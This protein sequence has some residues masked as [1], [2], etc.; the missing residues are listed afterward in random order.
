MNGNVKIAIDA[1]GGDNAPFEIVKGAIAAVNANS[2]ISV[3]LTGKKEEIDKVLKDLTF[4]KERVEIVEA[5]EII[6]M[7]ESPVLAIRQKKDSSLVKAMYLVKEGKCDACVSAGSTGAILVGGQTI[8]GRQKGIQRAP[9]APLIPTEKGKALLIDCGANVDARPQQL[10]QFA[11]IGSVYMEEIMKIKNPKVALVN[12]G[13]E[14]EKGNQ[15]VKETFPLLKNSPDIN[16][17][18]NI[19]ARDIPAG[20]ADV[21]VCDAFVGNVILKMYEGVAASLTKILKDGMMSSLRGKIGGAIVKPV[22]KA[23]LADYDTNKLGGA[24]MLGLNHLVI[25]AH[26]SSN[27]ES[28]QK[29]C[30]QCAQF[31]ESD[32]TKKLQAKIGLTEDI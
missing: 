26:G 20:H 27:A 22:L 9:L 4:D 29:A 25:K 1:M 14:E 28:F 18:G 32:M 3:C 19:E 16:F 7:G 31:H 12:I 13:A 5:N 6:E 24:P 17:V 23:T 10:M 11:K 21:V 30:E 15:L 8:I 2:G